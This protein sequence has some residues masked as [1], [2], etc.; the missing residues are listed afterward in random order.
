MD[1][2]QIHNLILGLIVVSIIV[3]VVNISLDSPMFDNIYF[4]PIVAGLA[5]L[6]N[7]YKN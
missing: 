6:R 3:M 7:K 5:F 4:L 1:R 2:R